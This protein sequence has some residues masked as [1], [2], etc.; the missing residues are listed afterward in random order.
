MIPG[1]CIWCAVAALSVGIGIRTMMRS[2]PAGFFTGV[3][4]PKV[5]DVRAYN[6]AVGLLWIAHGILTAAAGLPLLFAG[7]KSPLLLVTILGTVFLCLGLMAGYHLILR[8]YEAPRDGG[9]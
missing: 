9:A 2:D 7:K 5:R 3:A 6:R 8:K 4:P 1:F